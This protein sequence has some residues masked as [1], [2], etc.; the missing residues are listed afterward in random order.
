SNKGT[1]ITNL[2]TVLIK[3]L[4]KQPQYQ[5][6]IA[7]T[8][9]HAPS[10]LQYAKNYKRKRAEQDD[11]Q[12]ITSNTK[13]SKADSNQNVKDKIT[14]DEKICQVGQIFVSI[15]RK[16]ILELILNFELERII[17]NKRQSSKIPTR[18]YLLMIEDLHI[19]LIE[20]LRLFVDVKTEIEN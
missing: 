14:P 6:L 5:Y 19:Y 4:V 3:T 11:K 12:S 8:F 16:E 7:F 10:I 20:H 2:F 1:T 9:R 15:E 18:P 13:K 17:S